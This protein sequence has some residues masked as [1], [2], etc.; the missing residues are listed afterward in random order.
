MQIDWITVAAQIINFLVLVWLLHRYLYGPIVRAMNNREE[1][2]ASRLREAAESKDAAERE[3]SE[4][5]SQREALDKNTQHILG[6]AAEVAEST[7]RLLEETARREAEERRKEW[8][9][10]VDDEKEEF[11]H[12]MRRR[13]AEHVLALARRTLSELADAQLEE[14]V[15]AAFSRQIEDIQPHLRDRLVKACRHAGGKIVVQ[16][17]LALDAEAQRRITRAVHKG[18]TETAE[19]SYEHN[20]DTTSGIELRVGSQTL[21][22]NFASFLDEFEQRLSRDLSEVSPPHE[23]PPAA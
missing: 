17:A 8:L 13:S 18:I 19:V 22:W 21:A 5:R 6:R 15:A 14:R 11:L 16:T 23:E 12:D 9:K 20:E 2:I 10:Q 1:R 3:A 7:R 4:Y